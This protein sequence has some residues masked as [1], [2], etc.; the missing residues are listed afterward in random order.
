[1]KKSTVDIKF[2]GTHGLQL[3]ARLDLPIGTPTAYALFAHCFTCSKDT[4]AAAYIS[5]SLAAAGIAVLRFDFTGLGGSEG[6]FSNT[7]FSSNVDDLVAAAGFLR[8]EYEAPKLLVGHSLGG[9]AVLAAAPRIAEVAAVVTLNAPADPAHV[10]HNFGSSLEEIESAGEATVRLGGRPFVIRKSFV[11]D[12]RS[13]NMQALL[14]NLRCA[15]LVMHAPRDKIVDVS[16]AQRIFMPAKHPK[17]YIS[18]DDAD[19]LLSR[20]EDARYA[21][22]VLAAWAARYLPT[23]GEPR[24]A[25]AGEGDVLVAEVGD[26]N[27]AQ[28]INVGRHW[29]RADEPASIGGD[30]SGPSPYQLLSASLGACTSMTIRMY[31]TRKKWPIGRI[32]VRVHHEKIHAEDCA[33]CETSV[34]KVDRMEREIHVEAELTEEQRHRLLEIADK[35]PVHRTL[36]SEMLVTSRLV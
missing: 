24:A 18:L 36:H 11:D 20:R 30:D 13:Q 4:K 14:P 27:F 6:D 31:A 5:S 7:G 28:T 33:Q 16:N 34:G 3:A 32:S 2:A 25:Q 15:L 12:A 9:A 35:C 19:H 17:S 8:D 10:I 26:G 1:M 22:M 29:L 21:G 23:R